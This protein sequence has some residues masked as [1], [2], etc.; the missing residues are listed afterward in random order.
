VKLLDGS[1]IS[2]N[3]QIYGAG[4]SGA[5]MRIAVG[6][7][8]F[9]GVLGLASGQENPSGNRAVAS[10]VGLEIGQKAPAFALPDQFGHEQ[11]NETL[12]GSK[13]T[14]LLFFRSADW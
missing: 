4:E 10:V 8:F 7:L 3:W 14:V 13:G 5:K 6:M 11:S 9:V 2:L 12:K 1:N